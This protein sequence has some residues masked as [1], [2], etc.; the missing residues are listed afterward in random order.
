[1]IILVS[2]SFSF[3]SAFPFKWLLSNPCEK[4]PWRFY[5]NRILHVSSPYQERISN[6]RP[7]VWRGCFV[8]R[9]LLIGQICECEFSV[10]AWT[11]ALKDASE[12]Q[13]NAQ[14]TVMTTSANIPCSSSIQ[15][16]TNMSHIFVQ[17][18]YGR[19]MCLRTRFLPSFE[20]H[21]ASNFQIATIFSPTSNITTDPLSH[22][23]P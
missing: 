12:C 19:N 18:I 11:I 4:F 2:W 17:H 5:L 16:D 1:M 23:P 10:K 6:D 14:P 20:V 7:L 15:E 3:V 21:P 13:R 9:S 8:E 22:P